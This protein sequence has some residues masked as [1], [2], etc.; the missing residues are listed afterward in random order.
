MANNST[1]T[2]WILEF[3]DKL[4]KPL[5]GATK[6]ISK[7]TEF[8]DKMTGAVKLN[9]K[10][11]KQSL[12]NA[13]KYYSDLESQIRDTEKELKDLAKAQKSD[14]WSEVMKASQAYD[15]AEKKVERLRQ[16]LQGAEADV[17]DLTEQSDKF[18]KKAQKWTDVTT[19]INQATELMQKVV[20]GLDF[21]ADVGKLTTEV[22]RMTELS[23]KEL[24]SFVMKSRKIADIYEQD[25]S[26]VAR[27]ANV[28]T[29]Q[30]GGSYEDNLAL[31]EKGFKVGANGN[32]DFMDQLKEYS[33]F[34]NQLGLTSEQ[35]IAF[36]ANANKKGI[37]SDKAMDALK[38]GTL[39][40]K[41]FGQ[42][43]HDA[44]GGI[45]LKAKDI[46]GLNP[47]DAIKLITSKMAGAS[48]QAKQLVLTDIF[49]GAGEDAGL[50]LIEGLA[51]PDIYDLSKL[52]EIEQA[53]AGI[54]GFFSEIRTWAGQTFG[55]VG[56]YATQLAPMVMTISGMIPIINML[57][58][59]SKVQAV[60]TSILTA[61]QWLLNIALNANPISLIV[62][63]I[64]ALI[65]VVTT[66]IMKYNE[67]GA[68]LTFLLG[69][70][71]LVTNLV[72][73]FIRHWDS[74]VQ[75]FKSDG[76]VGGIKRIGLVILDSLLMPL[77]QVLELVAKI[78]P[79]G[80]AQKGV[81]GI[82]AFRERQNLATPEEKTKTTDKK[83]AGVN[84][85]L[86]KEP[87]VLGAVAGDK[88]KTKGEKEGDGLNVGSGSGGIKNITMTLNIANNF[89]VA[90]G[91]NVRQ[92][93]EQVTS[94]INDRLRDGVISLG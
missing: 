44:L 57:T 64:I 28:M 56:T 16:A 29:K 52:P 67:W 26:E 58:A 45:G 31:I 22:K 9:E 54:K 69:P 3:V 18:A 84:D 1:S 43:Q 68:A 91:M 76:I 61:K 79:T 15:K 8:V 86:Q 49:K 35:A 80:L 83:S 17:K 50:A 20:N 71:G 48:T 14:N 92:I 27:V 7:S 88:T 30:I 85:L 21:T 37:F 73:S 12:V 65:A 70:L 82:K 78:D 34:I 23:G 60:W 24:D 25:A 5:K 74:I 89:S 46:E 66:I 55:S 32:E 42:A 47:M 81:D 11:T 10:E 77:Q 62:I 19:G 53:G 90:Q 33:P 59:S 36:I 39:S 94:E 40:V 4:T 41:E 38:E 51:N 87:D 6:S 93:A 72:M 13:K 2:S 63:A 75:A